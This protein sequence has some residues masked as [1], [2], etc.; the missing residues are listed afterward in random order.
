MAAVA[1]SQADAIA[2]GALPHCEYLYVQRNAFDAEG[3]KALKA[4]T[5]PKGMKVHFGWPPPLPGVDYD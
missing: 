4:V 2:K 3:K 1:R 5:K